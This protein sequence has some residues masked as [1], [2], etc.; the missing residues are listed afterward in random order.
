MRQTVPHV[1]FELFFGRFGTFSQDDKG[2]GRLTPFLMW[3][4]N[5]RNFLHRRV[6]QETAFHHDRRNVL[7]AT[8]NYIFKTVPNF[9]ETVRVNDCSVARVEPTVPD[10][11][12]R[13]L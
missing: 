3:H 6:V 11:R 5:D 9:D 1:K 8:D 13:R 10:G 7:S 4:T 12:V 2:M